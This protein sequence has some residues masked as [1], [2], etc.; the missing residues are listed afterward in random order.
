[1]W[2]NDKWIAVCYDGGEND[3]RPWNDQ[4]ASVACRQLGYDGGNATVYYTLSVDGTWKVNDVRC[5]NGIV[6]LKNI[7]TYILLNGTEQSRSFFFFFQFR[8][9]KK[10]TFFLYFYLKLAITL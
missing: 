5:G 3:D 2:H 6:Y 4:A 7:I 9:Q 1:M 10:F 8:F